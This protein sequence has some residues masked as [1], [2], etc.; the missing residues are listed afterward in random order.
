MFDLNDMALNYCSFQWCKSIT[1]VAK[2]PF[3][4]N[5]LGGNNLVQPL[6]QP[7]QVQMSTDP[8]LR[9]RFGGW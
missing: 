6:S 4:A 1:A 2:I 9:T 5:L 3:L 7:L 8:G